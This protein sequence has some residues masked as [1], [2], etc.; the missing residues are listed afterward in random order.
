MS[1]SRSP[2]LAILPVPRPLVRLLM[3]SGRKI[4]KFIN[5]ILQCI[6]LCNACIDLCNACIKFIV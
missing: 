5:A 6:D 4:L 3:G 2:H 1:Y